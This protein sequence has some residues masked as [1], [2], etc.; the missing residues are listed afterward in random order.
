[1]KRLI[2]KLLKSIQFYWSLLLLCLVS[3]STAQTE[4]VQMGGSTVN[5]PNI[6][7]STSHVQAS[8][9]G[10]HTIG[11][12]GL[13][14]T[15][16]ATSRF[17][18]QATLGAD[19]ETIEEVMNKT[20]PVWIDE[21]LAMPYT[22][23]MTDF[24]LEVAGRIPSNND[25]VRLAYWRWAW[26]DDVMTSPDI[27]RA[28]VAYALSHIFVIS[29]ENRTLRFYPLVFPHYY[30]MLS[31]HALGNFRDLLEAVTYHPGMG[32]FLSHVNNRKTNFATNQF[33]DENYAREIM[34]LFTIG[35]YELNPDG[36]RQVD[37]EGNFIPTYDNTDV[38]ELAKIFTG[39]TF[40]D[41]TEFGQAATDDM[42][43]TS[44]MVMD[45]DWHD[46]N[47]KN[48]LDTQTIP[49]NAN[50]DGAA[51][52]DMALDVLFNHPNVGPFISLRL[53]QHLVKSNPS[54]AY[55]ER[56]AT[57]FDDNGTGIRGDLGAVVK[58][59]LLDSEARDCSLLESPTEGM[60]REPMVVYTHLMRAFNAASP[61]GEYRNE[62]YRFDLRLEQRPLAAPDIFS[63]YQ[64]DYQ[65]AGPI[66]NEGLVDPVF[67]MIND[68]N[69][70][71]YANM[72]LEWFDMPYD[73]TNELRLE[74]MDWFA[75]HEDEL[76]DEAQHKVD[77]DFSDELPLMTD[78]KL[79]E[80]LERLNLIL[81]HG[82]MTE[83]TR[84]TIY[85][86]VLQYPA[87]DPENLRLKMAL[88]LILMSPDYMILR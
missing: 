55:I 70:V 61:N 27:L 86:T 46:T 18:G 26:W 67:Q 52:V 58:A 17:L 43:F 78:T 60:L 62:M 44:P 47:S 42:S 45:N 71:G 79:G 11:S 5:P 34:Q 41:A 88:Y 29:E 87:V 48:I 22:H 24:T 76:Y 23:S 19:I 4:F 59:I 37:S 28:K 2:S 30:D 54:P 51:E 10:E 9:I 82:Q 63:F 32:V 80:L 6:T 25:T 68:N 77:L 20:F 3:V 74:Y 72:L 65:P 39:M 57:V 1:M 83:A 31:T 35:L 81:M 49:A 36:T 13:L 8:E 40:A 33:P 53:I 73:F 84:N 15:L 7:V 56:V 21:Q 38:G 75:L 16:V 85:H 12:N 69:L 14:P 50:P 66:Q 64:P